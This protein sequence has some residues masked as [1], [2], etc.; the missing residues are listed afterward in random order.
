MNIKDI[1]VLYSREIRAA[2]RD[3]TIV[4]NSILLPI[5]LY[6]LILWLVF[7][8]TTYISGQN[9]EMNS[10]IMLLGLPP[11]HALLARDFETDKSIILVNPTDP[12]E[13]LHDGSLD[14][15]VEFLPAKSDSPVVGNFSSRIHYDESRDS[16]S[17]ARSRADQKISRYRERYLA[18]QAGALGLSRAQFQNFAVDD[19]NVS[20]GRGVSAF[21]VALPMFF[22]IM[23]AVGGMHPAIDSTASERENSTWETMMT[24]ATSRANL[25]IAKYL[26]VATMAFTAAFLN[27]FAMIFSMGTVLSPFFGENDSLRIPLT[28]APVVLAGAILLALFVAAG[29][30][31][32]ASFA[33]NYK[34]G[35]S[36]VSPFYIALV[37]PVMFLQAPGVEFT[38]RIAMIPV[39]NVVMMIREAFQGIYHWRSIGITLAV[40]AACVVLALRVAVLVIQHEDFVMGS[41]SGS[42]GKF[43]KERLLKR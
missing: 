38:S 27:L 36:M 29:M 25:L 17:R 28:S 20:T 22:I 3:R 12:I 9:E 41:Y 15:L 6:P 18:Q 42:F 16:S 5:F 39:A 10:R 2:L 40:E 11:A 19:R 7:A 31:I 35:Q 33:R 37:M 30:M 34:E 1:R 4:T 43:A 26:Y 32:L 24:A 8:G 13:A 21:I 14:A 23:L